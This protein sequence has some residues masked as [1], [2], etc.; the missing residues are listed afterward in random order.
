[1]EAAQGSGKAGLGQGIIGFV[2]T[3]L[4]AACLSLTIAC[5]GAAIRVTTL[6]PT[7]RDIP[8]G[9]VEFSNR[10]WPGARVPAPLSSLD[11]LCAGTPAGVPDGIAAGDLNGDGLTDLVVRVEGGGA[12]GAGTEAH[13]VAAVTHIE[14]FAYYDAAIPSEQ[15]GAAL[16]I[17][18]RG[19]EFV[20]AAGFTDYFSADTPV[21]SCGDSV[22]AY[23]WTGSGLEPRPIRP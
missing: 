14:D 22:T 18:R 20:S 8:E 12:G 7:V 17:R 9:L 11:A 1:V 19:Q 10:R 23:F 2:R 4:C 15:R 5:G 21:L 16:S 3:V 6:S 13:L